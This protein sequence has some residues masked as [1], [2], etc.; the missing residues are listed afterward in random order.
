MSLLDKKET[1]FDRDEK[2]EIIPQTIELDLK[3][4]PTIRASPL[5]RGEIRRIFSE[6]EGGETT[7][8][9]DAE[10]ILKHCLEPK[11]TEE[12]VKYMKNYVSTAIVSAIL[13]IS[14]LR[15]KAD[16]QKKEDELKKK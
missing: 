5:T 15:E 6:A 1:M 12:E 7:K 13:S 3:D 14:G 10:I 16:W 4:K 11:Y 9:Q 8:D 2:G